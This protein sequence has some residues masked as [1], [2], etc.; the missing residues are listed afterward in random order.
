MK[1]HL[2][3]FALALVGLLLLGACSR[4]SEGTRTAAVP[5]AAPEGIVPGTVSAPREVKL[6][7]GDSMKFSLLRI[8]ARPGETLRLIL[9]NSGSAPK[10]AMG[11]NWILLRAGVDAVAY[12][13]AAVGAK[14]TDYV[15]ADRA[16]D[17]IA[18]SKLLGGK[19]RDTVEFTV[20]AETGDYTY[21]CTF[22]AHFELGM[23]GVLAVR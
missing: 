23:K 11:H 22:P 21:L 15:P 20:P 4:E 5:T 3:R 2:H 6:E 12:A 7:V 9:I 13:K 18:H 17:V 19:S 16:A 1:L 8:E 10:E 14:A